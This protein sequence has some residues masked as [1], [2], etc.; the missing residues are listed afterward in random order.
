MVSTL[1]VL[2][3]DSPPKLTPRGEGPT[4]ASVPP[5]RP[6]EGQRPPAQPVPQGRSGGRACPPWLCRGHTQGTP[7]QQPCGPKPP[8]LPGPQPPNPRPSTGSPAPALTSDS[9]P[10]R[11]RRGLVPSR[12][13]QTVTGVRAPCA[14]SYAT[15]QG[16]RREGLGRGSVE[17]PDHTEPHPVRR[18]RGFSSLRGGPVPSLRGSV[19]GPGHP[20]RRT[21]S[22][23]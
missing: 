1:V 14:Q 13:P 8:P 22:G 7:G 18:C 10:F 3:W 6:R 15:G 16:R 11:H 23:Y 17:P 9:S 20:P 4:V 12:C 2:C 19:R 21:L 5:D